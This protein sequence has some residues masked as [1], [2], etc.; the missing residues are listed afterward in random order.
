M[1]NAIVFKN[2]NNEAIGFEIENHGNKEVCAA[3]SMIS[4]NT[5]NA[6]ELFTSNKF[7]V[8]FENDGGYLKFF[9]S[10]PY[11]KDAKLLLDTLILGLNSIA[12]EYNNDLKIFE[13]VVKSNDEN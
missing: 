5:V 1:I 9:L 6:I 4:I 7:T 10:K 8:D 2:D 13:E 3:V 12:A 11:S